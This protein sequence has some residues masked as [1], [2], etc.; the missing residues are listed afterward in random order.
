MESKKRAN[1]VTAELFAC[2]KILIEGGASYKEVSKYTG[3]SVS[4]VGR[5]SSAQTF[6]E[7]KNMLAAMQ[8]E[9]KQKYAEKYNKERRE[10]T[11]EKNR[12]K[13][14]QD[15]QKTNDSEPPVQVVEHRQSVTVVANHYMMEE[16]KAQTEYLK[17]IK[18]VITVIAEELGC[19]KEG[20]K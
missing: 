14:V 6:T 9:Y 4:T 8:L 18:N 2:I 3:V 7:Y 5:V 16:L 20:K 12:E 10:K 15:D 1:P 17:L 13:E 19:F 11:Q